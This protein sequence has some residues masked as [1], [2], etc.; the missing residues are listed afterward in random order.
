[1]A[2]RNLIDGAFRVS[3]DGSPIV[4]RL[5]RQGRDA[6]IGVCYRIRPE[7]EEASDAYREHDDMGV[8]GYV[9]SAVVEAHGGALREETIG[10]E[11]TAWI[12]LPAVEEQRHGLA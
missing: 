5:V 10:P 12:R 4:V 8:S 1:M 3:E 2:L 9:T 6:E 7:E 11:T